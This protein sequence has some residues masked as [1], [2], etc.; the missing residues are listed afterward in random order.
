MEKLPAEE[1]DR[2]EVNYSIPKAVENLGGV[3]NYTYESK[4][5]AYKD[6]EDIEK[7]LDKLILCSTPYKDN[8]IDE[9]YNISVNIFLKGDVDSAFGDRGGFYFRRD[10]FPD[11]IKFIVDE[12]NNA[13]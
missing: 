8:I 10:K 7:V 3:E 2:V 9:E 13:K 4:Q 12:I 5:V 11:N 6:K 1:V